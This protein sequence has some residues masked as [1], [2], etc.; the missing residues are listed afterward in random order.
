MWNILKA[1][2]AAVIKT[3]KKTS[4]YIIDVTDLH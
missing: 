1:A 4:K 3:N 2:I